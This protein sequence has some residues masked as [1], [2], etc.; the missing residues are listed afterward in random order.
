[1]CAA[2]VKALDAIVGLANLPGVGA[3][4]VCFEHRIARLVIGELHEKKDICAADIAMVEAIFGRWQAVAHSSVALWWN[5]TPYR[6]GMVALAR[7]AE[8]E[9]VGFAERWVDL[10]FCG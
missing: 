4:D 2:I 8:R 9:A 6:F 7:D 1:M 5:Y 3:M 10:E